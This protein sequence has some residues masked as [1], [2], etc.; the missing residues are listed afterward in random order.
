MC[1]V[2]LCILP[3]VAMLSSVCL[4]KAHYDESFNSETV[5]NGVREI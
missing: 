3:F 5:A 4:L 1:H 2:I